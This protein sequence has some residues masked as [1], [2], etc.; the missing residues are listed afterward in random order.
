[1]SKT[2]LFLC[3]DGEYR[4]SYQ[5]S[6]TIESRF[7]RGT[8]D[9]NTAFMQ[10]SV[11]GRDFEDD[12]DLVTFEGTSFTLPNP[13][14]FSEGL[15]LFPGENTLRVRSVLS[16]GSVSEVGE[17]IV[18]LSQN[19]DTMFVPPSSIKIAR[20]D[21]VVVISA[22]NSGNESYFRGINFYAST[23][24]GGGNVGYL[25]L[26]PDV[27]DEPSET[28]EQTTRIGNLT[29]DSDVVSDENGTP[30]A[31]PLYFK[32]YA[33]QED[34]FDNVLR[35][36]Y[37]Q[38]L[39]INEN[40]DRFR[41]RITVDAIEETKVY[42]FTHNRQANLLSRPATIPYNELM[43]ISNDNPLYYVATSVYF[44]PVTKDEYET[45]FSV[46]VVGIP[47]NVNT[48]IS[49]LPTVS[50]RDVVKQITSS[51]FQANRNIAVQPGSVIR[52]T[53]IDPLAS[54]AVRLRFILDFLSRCQSLSTLLE[55]DDPANTGFSVDVSRSQYKQA[56]AQAFYFETPIQVQSLIDSSFDK[57][58]NNFGLVRLGGY[59]SRGQVTFYTTS[60]PSVDYSIPVGTIIT[61]GGFTFQTTAYTS[62]T[63]A[64]MVSQ[65]NPQTGF[66]ETTTYAECQQVG[67]GT[68]VSEGSIT[69]TTIQNV[70][71]TNSAKFFGGRGVETN[72]ELSIRIQN[73]ISSVD[74][75]TLHGIRSLIASISGVAESLVVSS[76]SPLML[77]DYDFNLDQHKG[78][79]I[80]VYIRGVSFAQVTDNFAFSFQTKKD[81]VF[82]IFGDPQDLIF[83]V[84]D[85]N[86]TPENPIIEILDFPNETPSYGM[87]NHSKG[88][89]FVLDGL[90]ILSYNKIQLSNVVNDPS[91]IDLTDVVM[92]DYRYRTSNTYTFA[93]QP[94]SSVQ[95]VSR[96]NGAVV[97][98]DSY[99]LY[100]K[101]SIL[102]LGYSPYADDCIQFSSDE[103]ISSIRD[104]VDEE[105]ILIGLTSDTLRNFGVNVL[106][107]SV[108]NDDGSVIY[109]PPSSSFPDYRILQNEQTYSI[110]RTENSSIPSGSTVLVSYRHD[111]NYTVSYV[112][113]TVL[114]T[115]QNAISDKKHLTADILVKESVANS[116]DI[117]ATVVLRQGFDI[118]LTDSLLRTRIYNFFNTMTF[119]TP[120][121]Q[122]DVIEIIDNTEGVSYVVVPLT[123]LARSEE[124]LVVREQ[125]DTS[126]LTDLIYISAWSNNLVNC[127]LIKDELDSPT[128]SG[129]GGENEYKG[130]FKD[131]VRM[132][133]HTEIPTSEGVPFNNSPNSSFIIG[134]KG[135]LIQGYSDLNT[136][137][138]QYPS[139]SETELYDLAVSLTR[140][141]VLISCSVEEDTTQSNFEITYF[142]GVSE[143]VVNISPKEME[144][145]T[146]GDLEF[147]YDNDAKTSRYVSTSRSIT[148]GGSYGGSN[149]SGGSSGSSSGGGSRGGGY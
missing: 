88:Y 65:Y 123:K 21:G 117:S 35:A 108:T 83:Q 63:V 144:Y 11:Y 127:Y 57:M 69:G 33:N 98:I 115:V 50:R 7:F 149:S 142:V 40:Y 111:E 105:H 48:T 25:L 110:Q 132:D 140:N 138:S 38:R 18:Y 94:V 120:I 60:A 100:K 104:V 9:P 126:D 116:V 44:D 8:C 80:D 24:M 124:S 101:S 32:F 90:V 31:D 41:S 81:V 91:D 145:L 137:Q 147:I 103:D 49:S 17:I 26:N 22:V 97:G 129:G 10:V 59:P 71:V 29:V 84:M 66:Y 51:I 6:T 128:V 141:R 79:K 42:S 2:P 102:E 37:N 78:G 95:D 55:I 27:I 125:L 148:M 19:N 70:S 93:R 134:N 53:F 1:M 12:P 99:A 107:V 121:R 109:S 47:L 23:E 39:E 28:M 34:R 87:R 61:G 5:F 4:S 118:S 85:V 76:G 82:E 112:T 133:L 77:R 15:R 73:T 68:N 92:G 14:R 20:A 106:T 131:G 86:L 64:N 114:N 36:E 74:T 75:G 56:L 52:D 62:I 54:E 119:G 3:P 143:G 96:Q 45:S 30:L 146:L 46:E 89:D 139:M 16:D 130:V 72:R 67:L 113:N 13:S 58:A 136:L 135:M 43:V 122:S